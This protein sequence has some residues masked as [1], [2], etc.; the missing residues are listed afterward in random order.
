MTRDQG[1]DLLAQGRDVRD[2]AIQRLGLKAPLKLDD[3]RVQLDQ[4]PLRLVR[5]GF[6][7][8]RTHGTVGSRRELAESGA[9]ARRIMADSAVRLAAIRRAERPTG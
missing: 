6:R 5:R 9:E 8:G 1:L 2:Q 4:L 7:L 3:P